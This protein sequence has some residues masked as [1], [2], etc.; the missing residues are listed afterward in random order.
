MATI[1]T[2]VLSDGCIRVAIALSTPK[3]SYERKLTWKY[4]LSTAK[5]WN[6]WT[7]KTLNANT[8]Y[9]SGADNLQAN[10]GGTSD[11]RLTPGKTYNFQVILKNVT[12]GKEI[13][14]LSASATTATAAGAY[15]VAATP[16]QIT[17]TVTGLKSTAY[18]GR[19]IVLYRNDGVNGQELEYFGEKYIAPGAATGTPTFAI[20]NCIYNG[21]TNKIKVE[22]WRGTNGSPETK[23]KDLGTK[24]VVV[25][26]NGISIPKIDS[27]VH[28]SPSGSITVNWGTTLIY[29]DTIATTKFTF[30]I[31]RENGTVIDG[32]SLTGRSVL[33]KTIDC[34][35][36][37]LEDETIHVWIEATEPN[38][39]G[40]A[41]SPE[42]E[43]KVGRLFHWDTEKVAGEEVNITASEWNRMVAYVNDAAE[44]YPDY[45]TP[46]ED[47]LVET[48]DEITA[49]LFNKAY[50]G[51]VTKSLRYSF[52][53][54]FNRIYNNGFTE[55]TY[56]NLVASG[57]AQATLTIRMSNRVVVKT[58]SVLE[59]N[60]SL[61]VPSGQADADVS[62]YDN[63]TAIE[64]YL[65]Y[66][67]GDGAVPL[68]THITARKVM[69]IETQLN[70]AMHEATG[71]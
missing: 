6:T 48:D 15:T 53:S 19:N 2:T 34:S 63:V 37:M 39:A 1:K 17:A 38:T 35:S 20:K 54:N 49:E 56:P 59:G 52:A 66:R 32:G 27:I 16:T 31:R 69:S 9:N 61:N 62:G 60:Y 26:W 3:S 68:V 25:P 67:T 29:A 18:Y 30:K 23:Y 58:M 4:K 7:S 55:T 21:K 46:I 45:F 33:T 43:I 51:L 8:T 47:G 70:Q 12:T 64:L 44:L 11:Q 14:T 42:Y 24:S 10:V 36:W 28:E 5:T 40:K 22:L 65:S 50:H 71:L 41:Q 13:Q 57:T